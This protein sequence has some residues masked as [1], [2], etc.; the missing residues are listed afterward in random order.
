MTS[1][2]AR[3][4]GIAPGDGPLLAIDA[5]AIRYGGREVLSPTSFDVARG[6]IVA[7]GTAGQLLALSGCANLED[8]FVHLA[9]LD[10]APSP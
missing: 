7:S 1:A 5:V 3:L 2:L 8:A 9:H 4:P 10:E 6:E